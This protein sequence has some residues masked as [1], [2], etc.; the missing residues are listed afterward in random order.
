M[1][2]PPFW[3]THSVTV[4]GCCGCCCWQEDDP[5][6]YTSSV[7]WSR[8]GLLWYSRYWSAARSPVVSASCALSSATRLA[9]DTRSAS[10]CG[11]G[12][13]VWV[14]VKSGWG[15]LRLRDRLAFV[16]PRRRDGCGCRFGSVTLASGVRTSRLGCCV[17]SIMATVIVWLGDCLLWVGSGSWGGQSGCGETRGVHRR[18]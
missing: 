7:A 4:G 17:S 10:S 15:A 12:G 14:L 18:T 3:R 16:A 8:R 5:R 1:K 6:P 11:C 2:Q 9:P 13:R